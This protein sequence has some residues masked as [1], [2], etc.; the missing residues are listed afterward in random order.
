[1]RMI[2]QATWLVVLL[3]TSA[4]AEK[5]VELSGRVVDEQGQPVAGAD[6]SFFWRA[7]GPFWD[8]HGKPV[9]LNDESTRNDYWGPRHLGEMAPGVLDVAKTDADGQ[10][11]L[12]VGDA[13]H[14]LVAMDAARVRGGLGVVSKS[15]P[16]APIEIRL[17]PL[18]RVRG[19]I[20]GPEKGVRPRWTHVC[21]H[22]PIDPARPLDVTRLVGCGSSEARFVMSLPPGRYSIEAQNK[23]GTSLLYGQPLLISGE[24]PEVDLGVLVLPPADSVIAKRKASQARGT[25]GDYRKHYGQKPPAW[26]VSDARGVSKEVQCSD[27]K[28]K[29][30]L[31][32]LWGLSCTP[33]L[34]HTIP[35]LMK[36]YEEHQSQRDRFEILSICIDPDGELKSLADMDRQLRPIVK[37]VWGGK[38]IPF[39]I[40]LDSSFRTWESFGL[41][42]LGTELLIDPD[43]K[44]VEGELSVLAEKLKR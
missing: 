34:K 41:N 28:G 31:V 8:K 33:C 9:D 4:R 38:T 37:N 27:F 11:E 26:Y 7:N 32:Y 5:L 13:Y 20:E 14:T 16:R 15:D 35:E 18:V 12:K 19:S 6:V 17:E 29:W 36:F 23:D 39:P 30:V 2:L 22:V 25:W 3:A 44:L 21:I 1:M 43:G 40:L 10:F 42:G 24:E